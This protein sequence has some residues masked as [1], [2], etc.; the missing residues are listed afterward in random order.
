MLPA[1]SDEHDR[2]SLVHEGDAGNVVSK[3]LARTLCPPCTQGLCSD[4]RPVFVH[5]T[6]VTGRNTV[7]RHLYACLLSHPSHPVCDR[8]VRRSTS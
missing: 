4:S 5:S 3:W 2:S 8:S 1:T 6:S 7:L